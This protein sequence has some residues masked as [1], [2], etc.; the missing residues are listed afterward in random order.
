MGDQYARVEVAQLPKH[1][2][3]ET[4]T[5]DLCGSEVHTVV[6]DHNGQVCLKCETERLGVGIDGKSVDE[7]LDGDALEIYF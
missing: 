7:P 2:E 4:Y 3:E 6:D 1:E 5:C